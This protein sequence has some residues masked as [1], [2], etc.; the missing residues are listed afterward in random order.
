MQGR[1]R[2]LATW[3]LAAL[4]VFCGCVII[5]T[6]IGRNAPPTA[7]ERERTAQA[8]AAPVQVAVP[9]EAIAPTEAPVPTAPPEPT[10]SPDVTRTPIPTL[11]PAPSSTSAPTDPPAPTEPP[12]SVVDLGLSRAAA[13][14][15]YEKAGFVFEDSTDVRG[16]PRVI[17]TEP[18]TKASVELIGPPEAITQAAVLAGIGSNKALAAESGIYLAGLITTV[19]PD[20]KEGPDWLIERIELM[21]ASKEPALSFSTTY[22]GRIVTFQAVSFDDGSRLLTLSIKAEG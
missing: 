12:E 7:Q 4:A 2:Q 15:P 1:F 6:I 5:L 9:T 10:P 18:R 11:P 19:M 8:A 3:A 14:S 13:Q 17:G 20:W 22:E 16:Q 21:I